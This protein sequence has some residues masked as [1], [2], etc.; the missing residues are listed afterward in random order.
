MTFSRILL[1]LLIWFTVATPVA[2]ILGTAI[3]NT[4]RKVPQDVPDDRGESNV[5]AIDANGSADERNRQ[6]GAGIR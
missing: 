4:D 3:R 2:V 1:V 5:L 6:H